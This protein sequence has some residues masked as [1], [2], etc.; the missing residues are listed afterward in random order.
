MLRTLTRFRTIA[1]IATAAVLA[2]AALTET[3]L[4]PKIVDQSR[5]QVIGIAASTNNA[6]EAG[7]DA[8]IGKQWHRFMSEGLLNKI[9]GRVDRSIVA[10]YPDY[11]S[12]A[13]GQYTVILGAK[14]KPPPILRSRMAW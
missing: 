4:H 13:N 5:F 3:T 9:P 6:K 11:T 8:I 7:P 1:V 14:V 2:C 10:V 12:D